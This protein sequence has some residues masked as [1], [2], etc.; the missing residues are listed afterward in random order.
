M[1]SFSQ[2]VEPSLK[3]ANFHCF[4]KSFP[5][6]RQLLYNNI[7]ASLVPL[8]DLGIFHFHSSEFMLYFYSCCVAIIHLLW[9]QRMNTHFAMVLLEILI[10]LNSCYYFICFYLIQDSWDLFPMNF[11]LTNCLTAF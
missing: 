3:N 9:C 5:S 8:Q 4:D 1:L 7:R 6:I 11:K 10:N 2:Q